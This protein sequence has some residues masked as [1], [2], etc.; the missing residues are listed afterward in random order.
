MSWITHVENI[1]DE[2]LTVSSSVVG[3][4]HRRLEYD[5]EGSHYDCQGAMEIECDGGCTWSELFTAGDFTV[6]E[7]T[8]SGCTSRRLE[9][10][11]GSVDYD[12]GGRMNITETPL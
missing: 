8:N 12:I 11:I 2:N 1:G 10:T 5:H 3:D 7:C 4:V 9:Y 6:S